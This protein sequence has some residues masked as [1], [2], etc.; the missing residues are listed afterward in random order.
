MR[1]G[2]GVSAL[3]EPREPR[4][5][6]IKPQPQ[7]LA[8]CVT[9]GEETRL[10]GAR[11]PP[12]GGDE[13]HGALKVGDRYPRI[14]GGGLLVRSVRDA[15]TRQPLPVVRPVGAEPALAVVDQ[16]G[17][18]RGARPVDGVALRITRF[19]RHVGTL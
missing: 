2:E 18:L 4:Y 7:S 15:L 12:I 14:L 3:G 13:L 9:E 5:P 6:P 19:H 16:H 11:A 10:G 8:A 1:G 17:P